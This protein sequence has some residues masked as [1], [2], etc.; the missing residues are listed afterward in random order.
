MKIRKIIGM[1]CVNVLRRAKGE[2]FNFKAGGRNKERSAILALHYRKSFRCNLHSCRAKLLPFKGDNE[3]FGTPNNGNYF[4]LLELVAKFHP[5]LR[6]HINRYG[7]TGSGKPLYLS[8]TIC[9]EIIQL[10]ANKMKDTIM[11]EVKKAGY[12]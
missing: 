12:F 7:N 3:N 11:A 2:N 6:D 8:K 10:M 9:H 4:G 1:L 5:F